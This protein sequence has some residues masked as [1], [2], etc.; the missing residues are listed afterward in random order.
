MNQEELEKY[1][2]AG[3]I[4]QEIRKFAK[5]YIKPG[6]PLIEIAKTIHDKIEELG[7]I[8]AFPV[9]L[10]IDDLA[11]HFHPAPDDKTIASG[12]L[13]VDFGVSLD[14]YI[15]D[16]ALTLDLTPDNKYKKLIEAS[17]QALESAIKLLPKNPTI[18]EIGKTI[19]ET[20]KLKGFFPIT[21]LS[22]HSIKQYN[23]HA[24]ITIPNYGNNNNNK[25]EPGAYA[26]EP[27]ATTGE[28]KIYEGKSGN[29]YSIIN[30]KMPRSQK[31]REIFSFVMKKYKT[32]PFSLREVQE[33]FGPMARLALKELEN[34]GIIKS[35]GQLI[36]KSHSPVTQSEHTV[37]IT[38]NNGKREIFVTTRE[39]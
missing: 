17:E 10:S 13:K 20:I 31:A 28:G 21:N 3:K 39:D 1:K 8:S 9:N 16:T 35:Y 11:A 2:Q 23:V 22:G 24:G 6:L 19:Q 37:I 15:A 34:Q 38:E 32:L 18:H 7:A 27:F 25:L 30:E 5:S 14:G 12:L 33:K 36:E 26:I 29:I 4:A